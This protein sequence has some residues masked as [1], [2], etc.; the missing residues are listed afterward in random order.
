MEGLDFVKNPR[1]KGLIFFYKFI[2]RTLFVMLIV[3]FSL[4]DMCRIKLESIESFAKCEKASTFYL[5]GEVT[6]AT[7]EMVSIKL[8]LVG[9]IEQCDLMIFDPPNDI[10]SRTLLLSEAQL[11]SNSSTSQT[12]SRKRNIDN[13]TKNKI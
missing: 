5:I 1:K 4:G 12:I 13:S 6:V 8:N 9:T 10:I 11:N 2:Q 3:I 7:S